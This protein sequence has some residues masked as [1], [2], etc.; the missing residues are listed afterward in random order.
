MSDK[1]RRK[2]LTAKGV[3]ASELDRWLDIP[4]EVAD[5]MLSAGVGLTTWE[6][7][8]AHGLTDYWHMRAAV[9]DGASVLE[10]RERD[11]AERQRRAA[12]EKMLAEQ[13]AQSLR[14]SDWDDA[15]NGRERE[16]SYWTPERVAEFRQTNTV[17]PKKRR[18]ISATMTLGEKVVVSALTVF[19]A[20]SGVLA[21]AEFYIAAL[22]CLCAAVIISFEER[23]CLLQR[24]RTVE[25]NTSQ[26]TED[27]TA[28]HQWESAILPLVDGGVNPANLGTWMKL[29]REVREN[30]VRNRVG[31]ED[32]IKIE[33]DL[34]DHAVTPMLFLDSLD[35]LTRNR[36]AFIT[37]LEDK[38]KPLIENARRSSVMDRSI[39][40]VGWQDADIDYGRCLPCATTATFTRGRDHDDDEW[41][42]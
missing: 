9:L 29:S 32:A 30:A 37:E 13:T 39:D 8:A 3:H 34:L 24:R 10:V 15:P 4:N 5:L 23:D 22:A 1:A 2:H 17:K 6:K 20:G 27:E 38:R 26:T 16:H 35:R 31:V 18:R 21:L 41:P 11:T 19:L 40:L 7:F 36:D 25:S 14:Y 42:F 28:R 12:T 33:L